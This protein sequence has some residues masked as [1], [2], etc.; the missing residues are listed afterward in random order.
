M[1]ADNVMEDKAI[2][3]AAIRERGVR[4][5]DLAERMGIQPSSLSMNMTR[6]R[7]GLD[8]FKEILDELGYDVAVIDR[9]SGEVKWVIDPDL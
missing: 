8:N 2:L 6:D 1:K 9:G 5:K 3:K 4:Q 7:M